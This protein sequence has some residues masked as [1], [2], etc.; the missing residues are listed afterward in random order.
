LKIFHPHTRRQRLLQICALAHT[1]THTRICLP[2]TRN[3]LKNILFHMFILVL[4]KEKDDRNIVMILSIV[5]PVRKNILVMYN[6]LFE[7]LWHIFIHQPLL[8]SHNLNSNHS[9]WIGIYLIK[10]E[11]KICQSVWWKWKQI[12][13]VT[14]DFFPTSYA[15]FNKTNITRIPP[16][17]TV[18]LFCI[19]FLY[20]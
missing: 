16:T 13:K 17:F 12:I 15:H 4:Y 11:V 6:T 2:C 18:F 1:H 14:V 3:N 20:G 8:P 19:A 10:R 9:Q 5:M 7:K